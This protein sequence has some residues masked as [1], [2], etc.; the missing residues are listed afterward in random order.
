M[1]ESIIPEIIGNAFEIIKKINIDP[2]SV[3]CTLLFIPVFLVLKRLVVNYVKEWSEYL[4]DGSMY[5]LS[6]HIKQSLASSLSLKRYCKLQLGNE[7][8]KF[9][10]I[11]SSFDLCLDIDKIFVNLTISYNQEQESDLNHRDFLKIGNRIKVM[12]DPGSGKSSLIKKVFRNNC[13]LA[14][15]RTRRAK[16]P[17]FVELKNVNPDKIKESDLGKW[18]LRLHPGRSGKEPSL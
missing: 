1:K 6:R 3:V 14:I 17:V 15:K 12:G 2:K 18:F 16:L 4:I 10:N 11:P 5:F 9:L 7:S 8:I 13:Q